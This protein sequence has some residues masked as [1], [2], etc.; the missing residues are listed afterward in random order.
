M[1][2]VRNNYAPK[3]RTNTGLR[4]VQF[5]DWVAEMKDQEALKLVRSNPK[6]YTIVSEQSQEGTEGT[7]QKPTSDPEQNGLS[8]ITTTTEGNSTYAVTDSPEVKEKENSNEGTPLTPPTQNLQELP[9][10][11]T[12]STAEPQD[13]SKQDKTATTK[14]EI[15][16]EDIST[17][18]QTKSTTDEN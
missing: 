18:E 4:I 15:I 14:K 13:R 7:L 11:L 2:I 16:T 6:V 17:T 5:K 1:K 8:E 3:L 9:T 12:P 10:Q